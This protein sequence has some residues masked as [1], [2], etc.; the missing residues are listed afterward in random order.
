MSRP[1]EPLLLDN[2][3][4]FRC[5]HDSHDD[6][7]FITC[8]HLADIFAQAEEAHLIEPG[9]RVQVPIF[10]KA[11]V[12][13]TVEIGKEEI[14]RSAPMALRFTPDVGR[15][16][17]IELGY[18]SPGEGVL[19]IRSVIM[20]YLRSKA[21]PDEKLGTLKPGPIKTRCPASYHN[22][23]SIKAMGKNSTDGHW[24]FRCIWNII[25]EGACTPCMEQAGDPTGSN[26]GIDPSVL[27]N[28][29]ANA[30]WR[31]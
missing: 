16:K 27:S 28:T 17:V 31:T 1:V 25:M 7:R 4:F 2:L 13:A 8:D 15:E 3:G 14:G 22:I 6:D 26:F 18:W 12:W 9:M 10:S 30:P 29:P 11:D 5:L 19:S 24:R 20:D 23:D 21:H